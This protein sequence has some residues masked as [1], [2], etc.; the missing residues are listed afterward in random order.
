MRETE[1]EKLDRIRKEAVENFDPKAPKR[2]RSTK[3][4]KFPL[5]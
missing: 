1:K 3:R 4:N 2:E 5:K